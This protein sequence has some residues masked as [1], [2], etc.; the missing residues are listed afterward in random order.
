MCDEKTIEENIKDI[1]VETVFLYAKMKNLELD[2][3]FNLMQLKYDCNNPKEYMLA[4]SKYASDKTDNELLEFL[5]HSTTDTHYADIL[6]QERVYKLR[7][8]IFLEDLSYGDMS[9]YI[10][11]INFS[12]PFIETKFKELYG[13]GKW[14]EYS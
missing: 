4:F 8:D 14:S 11:S 2:K 7:N 12:T 13:E 5:K 10:H 1:S 6:L 9:N 3:Y